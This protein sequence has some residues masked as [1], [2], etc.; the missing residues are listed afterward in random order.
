MLS[1]STFDPGVV[2]SSV[3]NPARYL[4]VFNCCGR[5]P[6]RT[7]A[8]EGS[9]EGFCDLLNVVTFGH[10]EQWRPKAAKVTT[11]LLKISPIGNTDH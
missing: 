3:A 1:T 9:K 4:R 6:Q 11:K 5:W 8:A 2:Y 7:M 10:N